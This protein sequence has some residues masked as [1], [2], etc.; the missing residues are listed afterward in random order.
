MSQPK[1]VRHS[2]FSFECELMIDNCDELL[3]G[4]CYGR[5]R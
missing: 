1:G 3:T 5:I 4:G 2:E